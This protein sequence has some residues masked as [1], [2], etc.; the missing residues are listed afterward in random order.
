VIAVFDDHPAA[1]AAVK[2]LT[3]AGFEMKSL[4]VIG[5]G[6]HTEEKVTGF[7]NLGDKMKIW[8]S[9][10]AFWGGLWGL[11]FG[12]MFLV[13][14]VVGHVMILGYIG[15]A[16]FSAVEGA[17]IVGG[18]G[19]LGAAL[20]TIGVPK[21]TVVHYETAIKADGFLVMA[22]GTSEEMMRAKAILGDTKP[23]RLDAYQAATH[24][25]AEPILEM[26]H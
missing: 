21:D 18:L 5:K 15:A 24:G 2:K 13:I 16:V 23:S 1:E 22:H 10:G 4:S 20:S 8:G 7:Y 6:Y 19:A 14:P 12:G 11:F 3:A 17:V 25:T 9:R 26:Q